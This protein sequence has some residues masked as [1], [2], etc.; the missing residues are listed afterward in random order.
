MSSTSKLTAMS[1]FLLED[2][3]SCDVVGYI[4]TP[5]NE[6]A[7][8]FVLG[9]WIEACVARQVFLRKTKIIHLSTV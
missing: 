1:Q 2:W 9:S 7:E 5:M 4:K 8:V 3:Y 6:E